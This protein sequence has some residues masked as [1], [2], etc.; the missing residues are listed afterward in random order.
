MCMKPSRSEQHKNIKYQFCACASDGC[1]F[2]VIL[3]VST[4][5]ET[6]NYIL[7]DLQLMENMTREAAWF[8]KIKRHKATVNK[9]FLK[10]VKLYL[11]YTVTHTDVAQVKIKCLCLSH[12]AHLS[13]K[14]DCEV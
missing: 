13:L 3:S 10:A 11:N 7:Q 2:N 14:C 8:F 9:A 6:L 12:V 4:R 1:L 5:L